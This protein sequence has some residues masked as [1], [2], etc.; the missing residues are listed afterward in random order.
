MGVTG[1]T[2]QSNTTAA[3]TLPITDFGF[4]FLRLRATRSPT[5]YAYAAGRAFPA[6]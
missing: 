1:T 3:M 5:A 6:A 2:I 4:V